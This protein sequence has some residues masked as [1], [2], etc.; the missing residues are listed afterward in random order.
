MSCQRIVAFKFKPGLPESVVR[1]HFDC[2]AG[3]LRIVE[4]NRVSWQEVL[5]LN[6]EI[7][8]PE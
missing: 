4:E 8:V 7:S 3:H 1:W 2:L 5:V 6:G